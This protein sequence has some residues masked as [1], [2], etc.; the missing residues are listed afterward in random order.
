M[1][2]QAK[3]NEL[4]YYLIQMINRSAAGHVGGDLSVMDILV[5]LYYKVMN[6]TP[7]NFGDPDHDRFILSKGHCADAL[8]IVLGDRGFFDLQEMMDTFS[9]Y[10]SRYIG[11]PNMDVP[12]IEMNGGSLG[13]GMSVAVGMALAAKM[14]GSKSR[15]YVVLGDGEM[16]EGSNYEGMMAAA[17][18][19]LDNLCATVDLNGL[20][21]SGFTKDVMR[22]DDMGEKFRSF[23]WNVI[24]VADGNDCSQ[25]VKAYEEAAAFKGAPSVLIAHT[26]K[27]KGVSYM[28]NVAAWHHGVMNVDQYEEAMS[29]LAAFAGR[30]DQENK[31]VR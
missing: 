11:H 17:H 5:S 2:L 29:E 19:H 20:Q 21:I 24:D 15:T 23:G 3:A 16:A 6:V 26:V 14:D 4:R 13:H 31:E 18:Y 27:G 25:L 10:G 8:Y 28:E 1:D 30:I 9:A 7:E 22:S 12:G